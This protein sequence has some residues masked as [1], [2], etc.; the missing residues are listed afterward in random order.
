MLSTRD[1]ASNCHNI[2][3]FQVLPWRWIGLDHWRR[4]N[5]EWSQQNL[6]RTGWCN[7]CRE[8]REESWE[9]WI[10]RWVLR[11]RVPE[12]TDSLMRHILRGSWV[13]W[14]LELRW[15]RMADIIPV[16]RGTPTH[17]T[18]TRRSCS[19]DW[20]RLTCLFARLLT[21]LPTT[22][23][24]PTLLEPTLLM[25]ALLTPTLLALSP[26]L[27][28]LLVYTSRLTAGHA[29]HHIMFTSI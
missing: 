6:N 25:P 19:L 16:V 15:G 3:L 28:P 26:Y 18:Q 9:I 7:W 22:L 1:S 17:P 5:L 11:D 27:H 24:L 10:I 8:P 14:P 4:L 13:V 29:I 21:L 2:I 12:G 20:T 23:L